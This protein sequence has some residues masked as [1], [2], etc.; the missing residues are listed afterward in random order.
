MKIAI[1]GGAS[2]GHVVPA[3]AV[4]GQLRD[5]GAELVFL[6][7]EN[8]IEHD[9]AQRAGIPFHHVPS[10]GLRRHR[11]ASNLLMPFTVARGI[12][13]AF[14]ALRRERPD[15]LFSKGSYVSVP[16]GIGAALAR[17]PVVI[18][19]SDHSLGLANKI[20][21]RVATTICLSVP[22]SGPT[23]RWMRNKTQVTGLP[24]RADLADAKPEALRERL[25]VPADKPVLL[26]FCGSSG[27]Q[28]VNTAVRAQLDAL[29]ER[30]SV[31][32]VVGKGNL[33]PQLTGRPGYWQLEYLHDDMPHALALA[34]LVIG[35]AG[36][37]TLAE[38]ASLELPAVL[39][40]LPASVSRGDQLDNAR[41]YAA[42]HPQRCRIVADEQLTDDPGAL[43]HACAALSASPRGGEGAR[44][45]PQAA[46]ER[47]ADLV[48]RA[49]GRN[50]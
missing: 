8:T 7:R 2:A 23:P 13:A 4:A 6:G 17:V 32:H 20:L 5:R 10:A 41:A 25:G 34:S 48:L 12:L 38:L 29:C 42:Q 9:Y 50:R 30:Y 31:L 40:P 39:V 27:S 35:R 36:A 46:A 37:T 33:E 11:S 15:A 1:T 24:L 49:A 14:T 44:P 18:H 43:V 16:V 28:R 26:I 47:I 45:R 19:E 22:A 21:G 3:L